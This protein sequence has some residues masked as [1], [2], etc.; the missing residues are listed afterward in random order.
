MLQVCDNRCLNREEYGGHAVS[1]A[2]A[3]VRRLSERG[4]YLGVYNV[5][6]SPDTLPKCT[7]PVKAGFYG[8]RRDIAATSNKA[9]KRFPLGTETWG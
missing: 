1:S 9:N 8:N 5:A 4:C 2:G 3:V 6:R 7:N